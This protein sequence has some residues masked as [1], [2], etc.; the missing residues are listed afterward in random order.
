VVVVIGAFVVMDG[1]SSFLYQGGFLLYA[2]AVAMQQLGLGM[3]L[4]NAQD[5]L[6]IGSVIQS[7]AGLDELAIQG[8]GLNS[9]SLVKYNGYTNDFQNNS[10]NATYFVGGG[11]D[12]GEKAITDFFDD[13]IMTHLPFP[14][15]S[16]NGVLEQ[17]N[18]NGANEDTL[19]TVVVDTNESMFTRVFVASDFSKVATAFGAQVYVSPA[20]ATAVPAA[21][22]VPGA[23]RMLSLTGA[24]VP[25]TLVVNGDTWVADAA[26]RYETTTDLTLQWYNAFQTALAGG[27]LTL[28]QRWEAQAEA[29]FEN[30]ALNQV[31]EGQGAIDRMDVQREIDAVVSTMTSLGPG[32]APLT[33]QNYIAVEHALQGNAALEELAVQGH[34]LNNP[35]VAGATKYNGYTNDFQVNIDPATLYVGPGADNGERAIQDFFDDDIMTHLPFASIA[36]N[37]E[38]EQLNQN[39]NAESTVSSAVGAMNTMLF[40]GVLKAANFMTPGAQAAPVAPAGPATI[41]TLYGDTIAGTMTVNGHVWT[42]DAT[43]KFQ[44]TTNLEME[45]RSDYQIMLAGHADTLT[46]TQRMEGNAEAVFENTQINGMWQGAKAESAYREDVQ[47]EIDA[48]AGAMSIDQASFGIN[49]NAPLTEASYLQLGMT[50]HGNIALEELALQGHGVQAPP[51]ARYSGA[52][53]DFMAGA[54]WSTYFTG[55]GADNGTLIVARSFNDVM[56]NLAF[57]SAYLNGAWQQLDMNGNIAESVQQAATALNRTMYQQVF[58]ASDFSTGPTQAG[59]VVLVPGANLAAATAI[60]SIVAAP[61]MVVTLSGVQIANTMTVN[62]HVWTADAYGAFHT[63]N[64]G[65]EWQAEYATMLAGNGASLTAAQRLEGNAE[66]VFENAGLTA[67]SASRLQRDREDVQ[68]QIDAMAGAMQ[69]NAAMLGTPASAVLLQGSY[70]A[71]E[72]TLQG[73]AALKELSLQGEGVSTGSALRYRGYTGDVAAA[74]TA[75]YIGGGIDSG[76]SATGTFMLDSIMG[77]TAFAVIW[78]NGKLMQLNQS[79]QVELSVGDSVAA[80]DG[81]MWNRT[82]AATDFKH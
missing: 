31:G 65:A 57:G 37:G 19:A 76:A 49:P 53:G 61:N 11:G 43:G 41:T 70:L 64:L 3:T 50:L 59:A 44:T 66:A 52:Y 29:V 51:S 6:N 62:G 79:G 46:A 81:A 24:L 13:I 38:L 48:I 28:T 75:T 71:A 68:R 73:N 12:T 42:A 69:I 30:T 78:H 63:V 17:L 55:G 40:G 1:G 9:P 27:P 26:G 34:G 14:V 39:G 82:Y 80:L 35:W 5:Y 36:Q 8:H 21:G 18:Q 16:E 54:D 20:M 15:V 77:N 74:G 2:I 72:R 45:W 23:G 56:S 10:D 7:S 67:I 33:V 4:L 32:T 22:P 25:T 60:S 47:R 58:V